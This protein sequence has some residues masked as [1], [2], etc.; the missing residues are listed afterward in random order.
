[1][2]PKFLF[3]LVIPVYQ[4]EKNLLPTFERVLSLKTA[5][6]AHI[7]LEVVF[8]DDGSSDGSRKILKEMAETNQ[9]WVSVYYLSR[10][11]GQT[12]AIQA[13]LAL[14][15][16]N[17]VGI[18]SCDLQEPIEI[19]LTLLKEWEKG[20]KFLIAFREKR[21]EGWLHQNLSSVFWWMIRRFAFS[22]FPPG[23]YDCCLLDREVV[24]VVKSMQEKNTNIFA[25]LYWLGFSPKKIPITRQK[26]KLGHSQWT[27]IKKILFTI[28]TL[29]AFTQVPAKLISIGSFFF[30]FLFT[31]FLAKSLFVWSQFKMAPPGWMTIVTLLCLSTC[32]LLFALGIIAEYQIRILDETRKRPVYIVEGFRGNNGD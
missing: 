24:E 16:G 17:C 29:F 28:D 25:L 20:S 19:F 4:N 10:N 30:A 1:M 5:L 18:I 21:E 6:P 3:S 7:G 8:V 31:V 14:A 9:S 2:I 22:C 11:F 26:R 12:P 23:G 27:F 15:K 32:L 13:G